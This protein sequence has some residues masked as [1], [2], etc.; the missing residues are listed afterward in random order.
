MSIIGIDL[1]TTNSLISIY[2][3]GKTT[4]I[5]NEFGEVLTPSVVSMDEDGETVYVGKAAKERLVITPDRTACQF[6]RSIGTQRKYKLGGTEFTSEELSSLILRRLKEDAEQY[7][8]EAVEEAVISVPAYFDDKQRSATKRA[9]ELAGF[10]VER[11]VNEPSAA[12]LMSRIGDLSTDKTILIFDFGGGTLDI[13]YA[14]CFENVVNIVAISGNNQLGGI[15]F[16]QA[17]A[18]YICYQ[19]KCNFFELDEKEKRVLLNECEKLK[20]SLSEKEEETISII[21]K[22]EP[23]IVSLSRK[24]VV[25]ISSKIFS[26]IEKILRLVFQDAEI[27]AEDIDEVILVGGSS[28]MPI[29]Q[30]FMKFI[31]PGADINNNASDTVVALGVGTYAGIKARNQGIAAMVLT[32]ICPFSLGTSTHNEMSPHNAYMSSIITRNTPL[33]AT[34]KQYYFTVNDDQKHILFDIYQGEHPYTKDNLKLGEIE[35]NIPRGPKGQESIE[36]TYSYDI[37]GILLI[38][39]KVVSTNKVKEMILDG[40]GRFTETEK[41]ARLLKLRSLTIPLE[42]VDNKRV[43]DQANR[44]MEILVDSRLHVLNVLYEKFRDSLDGNSMIKQKRARMDLVEYMTK[45]EESLYGSSIKNYRSNW[46]DQSNNVIP[47]DSKK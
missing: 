11:L 14:E 18:E 33:P 38:S 24:D 35:M 46:Y 10:R 26:K 34:R 1:G 28:K 3:D 5:P 41:A 13:S 45:V 39:L 4:L 7:L 2:R 47:F 29:V 42:S 31:L 20:R 21:L 36:A 22:E 17:I 37:N 15:D 6:K 27:E 12:A 25:S 30:Q 40:D 23:Y 32:D 9:G 16:D 43:F 8:G 44:L 19:H